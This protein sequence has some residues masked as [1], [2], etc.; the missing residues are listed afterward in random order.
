[1][2]P[3]RRAL[4]LVVEREVRQALRRKAT[5]V[6]AGLLLV[7]STA[8]MVVPELTRDDSSPTYRVVV[9]EGS[10]ALMRI[11]G[12][13]VASGDATLDL[14]T[15][16]DVS[17]A[18]RRIEDGDADVG[19]VGGTTPSILVEK[20]KHDRLVGAVYQALAADAALQRMQVAGL[21]PAEAR[22][23][24]RAPAVGITAVD[25]G[26]AD[27][28]SAA[29]VLS[30]VMYLLLFSLMAQVAGGTAIEKANRISEVLL[31][32]VRPGALLFG[33][34]IGVGLIGLFVL[35]CGLIPVLVKVILGGDLPNGLGGALAGGAAWFLLGLGLYLV[36]AGA[37]GAL[38]E[39]QEEVGTVI[40]PLNIT[41]IASY[42]VGSSSPDSPVARV[43]SLVPLSSPMVMPSRIAIG[44]ASGVEMGVSLALG[45]AAVVLAARFG[46]V[47]YRR[48]IVHT[49]RRLKLLDV[50]RAT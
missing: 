17:T 49:G 25:P 31:G 4:L 36:L 6:V 34:I 11:L 47:V 32:I 21:D 42:A 13:A 19:V 45:L 26:G 9:V 3:H 2:I 12:D 38:V 1:M 20:G 8:A 10:R 46:S 43:L 14:T 15:A 33:K 28:R 30:F 27:R 22:A 35:L 37:L 44:A 29:G 41:I 50:L 7:T 39:R 24:L 48:G 5:W 23:V 18:T 16:P 40:T